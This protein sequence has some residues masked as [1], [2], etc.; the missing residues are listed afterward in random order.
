M[1]IITLTIYYAIPPVMQ[2]D[3]FPMEFHVMMELFCLE[4]RTVWI[5]TLLSSV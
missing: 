3:G 2:L 1:K 4:M 5:L